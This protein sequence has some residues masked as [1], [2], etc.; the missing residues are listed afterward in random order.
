MFSPLAFVC[1]DQFLDNYDSS[2]STTVL[3][4]D[5]L[6]SMK[7]TLDGIFS[8]NY[9]HL[10]IIKKI[11]CLVLLLG[12]A[13]KNLTGR[14]VLCLLIV[15][16]IKNYGSFKPGVVLT[17]DLDV[18]F[19]RLDAKNQEFNKLK[20]HYVE[21]R[22]NLE[23]AQRVMFELGREQQSLQVEKS[24]WLERNWLPDDHVDN[25]LSCDKEFSATVRKVTITEQLLQ[26]GCIE[27]QNLVTRSSDWLKIVAWI[28]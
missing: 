3:R 28:Y 10:V 27:S 16:W 13:Y 21:I 24:R 4:K 22:S 5:A 6:M 14:R 12:I 20:S 2:I 1:V 17:I 7:C 25:C 8:M 11:V 18:F 15:L 9:H 26:Y 19:C 23:G